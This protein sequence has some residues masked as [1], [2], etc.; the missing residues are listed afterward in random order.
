M[1][2]RINAELKWFRSQGLLPKGAYM[3]VYKLHILC[4]VLKK[5]KNLMSDTYYTYA[6]YTIF[7]WR[8]VSHVP[9]VVGRPER[10]NRHSA[11]IVQC[12]GCSCGCGAALQSG[13]AP[14]ARPCPGLILAEML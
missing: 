5:K 6:Y 1:K 9:G 12:C 13:V 3:C 4:I 7:F 11:A 2:L 8:T 10:D 14:A